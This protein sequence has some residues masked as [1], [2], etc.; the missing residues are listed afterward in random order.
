MC[1]L[2]HQKQIVSESRRKVPKYGGTKH[3]WVSA[4]HHP[5]TPGLL[6]PQHP[7]LSLHGQGGLWASRKQYT[8]VANRWSVRSFKKINLKGSKC[9]NTLHCEPLGNQLCPTNHRDC[10]S[11]AH[12]L[13]QP[14]LPTV[15]VPSDPSSK[16]ESHKVLRN[17]LHRTKKD[18]KTRFRG[19]QA[20]LGP[21]AARGKIT[22]VHCISVL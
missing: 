5:N 10:V 8:L 13:P 16:Y 21:Q 7:T 11:H 1:P 19:A 12:E 2:G 20:Y 9:P 6:N 3:F 15:F 17:Q 14:P 4:Q 18:P 22:Q